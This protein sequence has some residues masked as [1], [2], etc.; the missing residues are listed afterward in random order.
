MS[1]C[2]FDFIPLLLSG[3]GHFPLYILDIFVCVLFSE[4]L[5]RAVTQFLK[6]KFFCV[7]NLYW[8]CASCVCIVDKNALSDVQLNYC[9]LLSGSPLHSVDR[10]LG[11][12]EAL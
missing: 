1:H 5:F 6:L 7:L 4:S 12:T 8:L 11:S 2:D 3:D 9:L 10:M